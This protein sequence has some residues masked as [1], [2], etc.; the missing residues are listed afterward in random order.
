[1]KMSMLRQG[2]VKGFLVLYSQ[3]ELWCSFS[4]SKGYGLEFWVIYNQNRDWICLIH[5]SRDSYHFHMSTLHTS[6][7]HWPGELTNNY[8]PRFKVKKHWIDG[9]NLTDDPTSWDVFWPSCQIISRLPVGILI[10]LVPRST[11]DIVC[12][13]WGK[14]LNN[15]YYR[16]YDDH[17]TERI[18]ENYSERIPKF[19]VGYN[20][21]VDWHF[22]RESETD[23]YQFFTQSPHVIH[24]Y[25]GVF[26]CE[27]YQEGDMISL[28]MYYS[29]LAWAQSLK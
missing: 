1:M 4:V 8:S 6:Y 29:C 2:S 28:I 10:G 17:G 18:N 24:T 14:I 20:E 23:T 25:H 3:I 5:F 11:G 13:L 19:L 16:W 27:D 9:T 7:I 15:Q 22:D 12:S 21:L 26:L